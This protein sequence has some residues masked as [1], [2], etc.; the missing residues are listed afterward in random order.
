MLLA[1]IFLTLFLSICSYHPSLM[2]DLPD[3][4]LYMHRAVGQPTLT[5]P[6]E[7]VHRRM[8]LMTSS[9]L[10]QQCPTCLVC[11]T[12]MVLEMGCKGLYSCCFVGC[13][14]HDLFNITCTI[15]V[16]LPSSFFFLHLI[17][18]YLVHP[19]SS[20]AWK[21][22][23][24]ILSYRSDFHMIDS[25]SIAVHAFARNILIS[26]SVDETLLPR[27]VNLSTNFRELPFRVE[28]FLIKT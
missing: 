15:L 13:C 25:L 6:Y 11:F 1:W 19:Y 8:L 2:A 20:I 26:L 27:Y 18:V 7:G 17:C 16:Q 10:L 24:F 28:T 3:Y 9:L 4:I 5:H 14:F 22:S 12:C 21:K 23:R